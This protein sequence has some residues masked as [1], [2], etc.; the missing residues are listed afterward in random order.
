MNL[1]QPHDPGETPTLVRP[2]TFS[3]RKAVIDLLLGRESPP[4]T[5]LLRSIHDAGHWI[6]C[7]CLERGSP[8]VL[9]T[10]RSHTGVYALVRMPGRPAHAPGCPVADGLSDLYVDDITPALGDQLLQMAT[11]AGTLRLWHPTVPE[12]PATIWG[13]VASMSRHAASC[14]AA[15]GPVVTHPSRLAGLAVQLRQEATTS[16]APQIATA[17][18][19]V[20]GA[21]RGSVTPLARDIDPIHVRGPIVELAA[22]PGT[23]GS[24]YVALLRIAKGTDGRYEP[25]AAVLSPASRL[26][27]AVTPSAAAVEV[28]P[29]AADIGRA[30]REQHRLAVSIDLRFPQGLTGPAEL[31]VQRGQDDPQ[32]VAIGRKASSSDLYVLLPSERRAQASDEPPYPAKIAGYIADRLRHPRGRPPGTGTTPPASVEA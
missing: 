26:T 7:D 5:A 29:I 19:A 3:E 28:A 32:T 22:S 1:C 23:A 13:T 10:R 18:I 11:A 27:G 4:P 20:R 21:D 9:H 17:L 16:G 25:V 6:A 31:L 15:T 12:Q 30:L 24:A 2:L 14:S 8:P